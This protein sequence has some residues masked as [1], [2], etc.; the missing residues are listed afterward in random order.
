MKFNKIVLL[1]Q[2]A[3]GDVI[4]TTGFA[5]ALRS[6]FPDSR[7]VLLCAPFASDLCR[8]P[9]LDEVIPYTKGMPMFPV[10]R[11]LWH[12]DIAMCLDFKYRSAVIP[13]FARIPVRAGLA[14]KRRLFMT[15]AVERNP[16]HEQMY[17][18]DHLADI[19]HRAIGLEID[20]DCSQLSVASA[21]ESDIDM[22]NQYVGMNTG[23]HINVAISP[24]SSTTMKDWPAENY[25]AFMS[26]L[27]QKFNVR[28][29]VIGGPAEAE[30]NFPI[31]DGGIDL[32]GKLKI[33]ETAE[34]L[35]R[36]DYFV[37]SCSAPLHIAAAV[38]LPCLAFYGPTSL[39]KWAPR[40]KCI[41]LSHYRSCSPCDE[42]GYGRPCGFDNVCIKSITVDEAVAGF[43]QLVRQW[44]V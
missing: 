27:A 39:N 11:R 2:N 44:P 9:C 22:V 24:F 17:F 6:K 8:I 1:A 36:M 32:R 40:N 5:K 35:R 29:Y 34:M 15:H 28:F 18:A 13:F 30:R 7:I 4:L 23:D 43:D 20:E 3:L 41:T 16:N 10:I 26:A 21:T 14:H 42:G 33:T 31:P 38:N 12:F 25:K 19:M 37:G